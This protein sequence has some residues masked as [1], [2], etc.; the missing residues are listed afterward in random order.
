MLTNQGKTKDEDEKSKN[1]YDFW[2]HHPKI[3]QIK[4]EKRLRGK[5]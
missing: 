4:V 5:G 3:R 2:T 1:E